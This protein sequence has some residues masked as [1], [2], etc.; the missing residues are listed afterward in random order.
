MDKSS[1]R[2]VPLCVI[3]EYQGA[4]GHGL[5][6]QALQSVRHVRM[7]PVSDIMCSN[8]A[9]GRGEIVVAMRLNLCFSSYIGHSTGVRYKSVA[10]QRGPWHTG[11][12]ENRLGLD[13][14]S[15]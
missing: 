1:V 13:P 7:F 6:M 2:L 4:W 5:E 8:V 3:G 14:I 15:S 12:C 11:Q 9:R 10:G